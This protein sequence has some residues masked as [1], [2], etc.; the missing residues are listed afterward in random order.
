VWAEIVFDLLNIDQE[1]TFVMKLNVPADRRITKISRAAAF[2]FAITLSPALVVSAGAQSP[3]T[4]IPLRDAWRASI[5]HVPV[6][7]AGCFTADYPGTKW[8]EV[9]CVAAPVGPYLPKH[10]TP[11][12]T[13]TVG[14]GTDYAAVVTG[15]LSTATGS[16]PVTSDLNTEKG[17]SNLANTYS[18]Q[19]NTQFMSG[20]SACKKASDPTKCLAWQQFVYSSSFD[21]LFMQYWLIDYGT[22]CPSG[23]MASG[24]DCYTNSNAATVPQQGIKLLSYLNLTGSAVEAGND[25]VVLTT[26]TKAYSVTGK[27]SVVS[28]AKHWNTGE[29][30]IF[31]DGNGSAANVNKGASITVKLDLTNG[32]T[33]KP[34]CKADSGTTAETNNMTL[35]TCTAT[36]GATPSI[37]FPE[38]NPTK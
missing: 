23:W 5:A 4:E 21:V 17:Y 18:L 3:Q 38:S 15:L 36:G 8:T 13:D 16:F 27:D 1:G 9:A 30:N 19:L 32:K 24:S 35:G 12:T 34:K 26:K 33:A 22:T 10:G 20:N 2:A 14:D 28:L 11:S 37:S 7:H 25:T 31:G 6:P 29:F